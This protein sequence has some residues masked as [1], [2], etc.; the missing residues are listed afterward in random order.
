MSNFIAKAKRHLLSS[1]K[2]VREQ[3][4]GWEAWGAHHCIPVPTTKYN[5]KQ[6]QQSCPLVVWVSIPDVAYQKRPVQTVSHNCVALA[7]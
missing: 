3:G 7:M 4:A 6:P 5:Q 1:Y 2:S